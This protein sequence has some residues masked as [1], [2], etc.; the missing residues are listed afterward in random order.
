MTLN[1]K[2]IFHVSTEDKCCEH[3]GKH[4]EQILRVGKLSVQL[5]DPWA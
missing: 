3:L 2:R 1:A 4:R 5:M